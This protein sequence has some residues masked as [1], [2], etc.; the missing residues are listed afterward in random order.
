MDEDTRG[1]MFVA[2]GAKY[3]AAANEAARSVASK[4]P[5]LGLA[6]A[7]DR[8]DLADKALFQ[9]LVDV[10][11]GHAR[12]KVDYLARTPF[13]RT[14]YLDTDIRLLHSVSDV[15]DV[16]DRFD[17]ALAHANA[18]NRSATRSVWRTQIPDAFPQLNGG[19]IAYR[20]TDK[21]LSFL[22]EW[23]KAYREADFKKDQV[24]LRELLWCS[25]LRINILPPEYNIRYSRYLDFWNSKEAKPRI[26]HLALYH[27]RGQPAAKVLKRR[28]IEVAEDVYVSARSF[29][30]ALTKAAML[31]SRHLR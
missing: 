13:H 28:T 30:G 19:V 27:D 14:L 25:E 5:E 9:H 31:G 18:R 22:S 20:S 8:T 2:T 23:S 6:L 1:V 21:V 11:D 29:V 15:F 16:L 12:S 26:L 10:R 3:V 7:T 24:T 4:D 17:I